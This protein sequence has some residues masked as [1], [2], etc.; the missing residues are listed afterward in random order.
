MA[1][2]WDAP[3]AIFI[4]ERG[5]FTP[6]DEEERVEVEVSAI[7]MGVEY[8]ASVTVVVLDLPFPVRSWVA[9]EAVQGQDVL[10]ILSDIRSGR[11]TDFATIPMGGSIHDVSSGLYG[12]DPFEG[13][14]F[15]LL[16]SDP[17][18]VINRGKG[19]SFYGAENDTFIFETVDPQF[20][21]VDLGE[22][23]EL[24]TIGAHFSAPRGDRGVDS[25]GV[26]ISFDGIAYAP[27][28]GSPIDTP[29]PISFFAVDPP[30][31][32]RF[33]AYYFGSCLPGCPGSRVFEVYAIGTP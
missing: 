22:V 17:R 23:R 18:D 11:P 27:L 10:A 5:T 3:G 28:S 12:T 9:G 6:D 30:G 20:L 29:D 21:I 32:A 19:H 7:Y 25:F 33:I 31:Q 15:R 13:E 2:L 16:C 4:D 8:T 26:F 24:Y 1:F 14:T